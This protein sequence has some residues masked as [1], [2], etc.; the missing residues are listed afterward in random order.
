METTMDPVESYRAA[1]IKLFGITREEAERAIVSAEDDRGEWAPDS[2][3][4]L[5]LEFAC[6][7]DLDYWHTSGNN[8]MIRLS[9]AAGVGYVEYV[10]AAVAAV[11]P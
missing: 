6:M 8:N 7:Q 2:L 9:E 10:N 3:V 5:Y 11:Y 4:V 1:A